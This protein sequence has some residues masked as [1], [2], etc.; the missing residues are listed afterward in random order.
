MGVMRI[1]P[2]EEPP[3]KLQDIPKSHYF[4]IGEN[5][6]YKDFQGEYF[7]LI[8]CEIQ[9]EYP[10]SLTALLSTD[11]EG[12]VLLKPTSFNFTEK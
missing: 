6:F 5:I 9:K 4:K 1:Q 3:K 8:D 2:K 7:K 11:D 10:N 12:I